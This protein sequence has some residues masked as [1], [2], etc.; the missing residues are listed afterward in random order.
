MNLRSENGE[1]HAIEG[2]LELQNTY[3]PMCMK[4]GMAG[5]LRA[6]TPTADDI[7]CPDCQE[8]ITSSDMRR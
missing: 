4:P 1:I 3:Q 7:T 5:N 2:E 6:Y 8:R